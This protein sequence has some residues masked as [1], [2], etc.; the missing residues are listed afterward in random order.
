MFKRDDIYKMLVK[1]SEDHIFE[2]VNAEGNQEEFFTIALS[3]ASDLARDGN[4]LG[5]ACIVEIVEN[6]QAR[7]KKLKG[8]NKVTK[9][10]EYIRVTQPDNKLSELFV[11]EGSKLELQQVITEQRQKERL[12][13]HN[14]EPSNKL[15][16]VGKKGCGQTMAA[17]AIAGELNKKLVTIPF[18]NLLQMNRGETQS[19]FDVIKEVE[20]VYLF[21]GFRFYTNNAFLVDIASK[22]DLISQ[23]LLSFCKIYKGN[24]LI[25]VNNAS[26][27]EDQ[28][29]CLAAFDKIIGFELPK[30]TLIR[31]L[32]ETGLIGHQ[33]DW[34]EWHEIVSESQGL[35]SIE[36]SKTITQAIKESILYSDGVVSKRVLLEEISKK[37]TARAW[38]S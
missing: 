24:S 2:I 26:S 33:Y 21:N 16:F 4:Q 23:Y 28:R 29:D 5:S 13:E 34:S 17:Q 11:A 9:S 37:K 30:D 12:R 35:T 6:L 15:L 19:L 14:I 1:M 22:V 38:L 32:I 10:I 20:A 18:Y 3:I 7:F 27:L 25:I 8:E 36:I 31:E